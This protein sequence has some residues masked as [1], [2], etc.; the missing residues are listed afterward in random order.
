MQTEDLA[1]RL[2]CSKKKK[3]EYDNVEKNESVVH[4][5]CC[6]LSTGTWECLS[7]QRCAMLEASSLPFC[8]TDWQSSGW[9]CHSSSLVG[10][11][12]SGRVLQDKDTELTLRMCC[13]HVLQALWLSWLV[14]WCCCFRRPE[15]CRCPTPS[16]TS[17]SQRSE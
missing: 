7:V 9:S 1:W 16:T 17:S 11:L 14:V 6:F 13:P 5:H 12:S 10:P 4:W 2:A 3:V 15:A 8:S